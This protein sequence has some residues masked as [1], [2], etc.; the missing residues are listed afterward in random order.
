[1]TICSWIASFI[2][3]CLRVLI[4]ADFKLFK[5]KIYEMPTDS[6]ERELILKKVYPDGINYVTQS[7]DHIVNEKVQKEKML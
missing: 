3:L 4:C 6:L 2:I 5:I 7:E 1:M